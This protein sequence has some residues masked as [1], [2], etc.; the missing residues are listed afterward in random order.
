MKIE[1]IKFLEELADNS[2]FLV[3]GS[4]ACG[5]QTKDSD[6]DFQIKTPRESVI[7]GVRNKNIDFLI[8][9]LDKY[10]IK[11]NST[12]NSYIS[13]ISEK[14]NIPIQLEFYD[15]F[16]RNKNKFSQVEISG[17]KFKTY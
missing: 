10:K 16:Y 12:R 7:Y 6:I 9:L 8:N 1:F 17:V 15:N 2:N 14:N 5:E 4:Y 13:T 3:S 11:W